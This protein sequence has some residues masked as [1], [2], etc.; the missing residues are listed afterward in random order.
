MA[1]T[2]HN[3]KKSPTQNPVAF[4]EGKQST[5]AEKVPDQLKSGK[6]NEMIDGRKDLAKQ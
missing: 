3:S 4:Y 6:M 1:I 5:K 2:K